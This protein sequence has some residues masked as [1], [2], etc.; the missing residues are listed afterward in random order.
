MAGDAF[1]PAAGTAATQNLLNL[2]VGTDANGSSNGI[3]FFE[4]ETFGMKIGYDGV[5]TGPDNALR[6]YDGSDVARVSFQNGGNVGIGTTSPTEQLHLTG[7]LRLEAL[8]GSGTQVMVVDNNG[9]VGTQ[10]VAGADNLGNHIATQPIELNNNWLSNDGDTEGLRVDDDGNVGIATDS[11]LGALDVNPE[12]PALGVTPAVDQSQTAISG[13]YSSSG[14]LGV[15]WQSFTAGTDGYLTAVELNFAGA[16]TGDNRTVQIYEGQGTGGTQLASTNITVTGGN[17]VVSF[18]P[19]Q[20]SS[21][22][23]YTFRISSSAC[24]GHQVGNPYGGGIIDLS[25][26]SF[27]PNDDAYFRTFTVPEATNPAF[28]VAT[29]G[30]VGIGTATPTAQLHTTGSVRLES[31]GGGGTQM[32]VTD[33][34]GNLSTQAIPSNTDNQTL[35][36]AG[37]DLSISGGNTV[38]LPPD[39]QT[40]A[41]AGQDLSISGGNTV[42]LPPDD[43]TLSVSGSDL[44][45][46]GGNT[47]T[48]PGDNLGNHTATTTLVMDDNTIRLRGAGDGNHELRY[49]GAGSNFAGFNPDGSALYGF[50]GGI[51]GSTNGG[52]RIALAWDNNRRVGIGVNNPGQRLDVDGEIRLRQGGSTANNSIIA[53]SQDGFYDGAA[54]FTF[55]TLEGVHIENNNVES[56]GFH[57]DE[58]QADIWSPGDGNRLLRIWDEDGMNEEAYFDGSGTAHSDG[59]VT[60]SDGRLKKNIRPLSNPLGLLLAME[61][62]Q[63]DLRDEILA[64][65]EIEAG[66]PYNKA[67]YQNHLG[68]IAQDLKKILPQAVEYDSLNQRYGVAYDRVIPVVV[69]GVQE[70]H[71]GVQELHTTVETL[72]SE[73]A[74]L[75]Q[76]NQR[77]LQRLNALEERVNAALPEEE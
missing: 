66:K 64:A 27:T 43:Q 42:T 21:G 22:T 24:V 6:I 15:L 54:G 71:K 39:D 65:G 76:Q 5:A 8:G 60:I 1:T 49:A 55:N 56:A 47:V 20:I 25:V 31:L 67:E 2:R 11:P 37:Q 32:L 14:A 41:L 63:Y 4:D 73:N 13:Q 62:V 40:L 3:G 38:T 51:L 12:R 17:Q 45:I 74:A 7:G 77:L 26:L 52:E 58:D 68:F 46:S 30:R 59:F 44:S 9:V 36:L 34:N 53:H 35:A 70:M 18:P 28:L 75:R 29:D 50:G 23:Q 57:A 19:V 10:P 33:N 61:G 72:Q 48:L 16:C 69:E